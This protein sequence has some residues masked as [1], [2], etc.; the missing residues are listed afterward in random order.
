MSQNQWMFIFWLLP[1]LA[2]LV[3]IFTEVIVGRGNSKGFPGGA[4]A[5]G[6]ATGYAL[7]D[8]LLMIFGAILGLLGWLL[9]VLTI[10]WITKFLNI[11]IKL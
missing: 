10:D 6:F 1:V 5:I 11:E 8:G 4:L 9:Y 3:C 2:Y 7:H